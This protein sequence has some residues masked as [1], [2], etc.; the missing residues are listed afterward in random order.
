MI[1]V[2]IPAAVNRAGFLTAC[3]RSIF[4]QTLP[5]DEVVISVDGQDPATE[6]VIDFFKHANPFIRV[7][8][9]SSASPIGQWANRQKAF[10]L[11]SGDFV[12]ML[13]DD[14]MWHADFLEKTYTRLRQN[15]DCGFCFSKYYLMDAEE[16][17]LAKMT[18]DV[19]RYCGRSR[20]KEGV[21]REV[22][23]DILAYEA[24]PIQISATLFRRAALEKVGFIPTYG[25]HLPDLSL[26]L[27]LAANRTNAYF[28]DERLGRYRVH[29]GQTTSWARIRNAISKVDCFYEIRSRYGSKLREYELAMLKKRYQSA[30][31][32]CA[33]SHVH[34]SDRKTAFSYLSRFFKTGF[35]LPSFS[36]SVVLMALLAGIR[37]KKLSFFHNPTPVF[38][39][40]ED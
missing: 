27:E 31:V 39:Y 24:L 10:R 7:K 25:V 40:D 17:I 35:G 8:H 30:I 21:N 6:E 37:N 32:E 1:S 18:E 20:M 33:I 19:D 38:R 22:L 2:A 23:T 29:A 12:A 26:F 3:L 16:T 15:P 13:D 14:D 4:S 9:V 28:I 36:R 11:T 34:E 5:P